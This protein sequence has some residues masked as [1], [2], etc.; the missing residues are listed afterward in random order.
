MVRDQFVSHTCGTGGSAS[1]YQSAE[2]E[3]QARSPPLEHVQ[4]PQTIAELATS[5][6]KSFPPELLGLVFEPFVG[7]VAALNRDLICVTHVC[8]YWRNVALHSP[9]L[10]SHI[11][12]MHPGAVEAFLARSQTLPLHILAD[13]KANRNSAR[14]RTM[15]HEA[16]QVLLGEAACGRILSL[17]V[18]HLPSSNDF[19]WVLRHIARAASQLETLS[20]E[21]QP[22]GVVVIPENTHRAADF[23]G[24]PK[25][26]SLTLRYEIPPL[27]S[28]T[29]NSLSTLDLDMP[30]CGVPRV[31][32]LL[33]CSPSLE[34]LIIRGLFDADTGGVMGTVTLARLR[35]FHL[36]R[37]STRVI[38]ALLSNIALPCKRVNIS[39]YDHLPAHNALIALHFPALRCLKRVQLIWKNGL[40]TLRAYRSSELTSSTAP[41]LQVQPSVS[42]DLVEFLINWPI[43]ASHIETVDINGDSTDRQVVLG[44]EWLWATMLSA[45]PALRTLRVR[46]VTERTLQA[47]LS[48]LKLPGANTTTCPQL[49]TLI[50]AQGS[51]MGESSWDA[52]GVT[53]RLRG[54]LVDA[55]GCLAKIVV[56]Q[57][58]TEPPMC[59]DQ[60]LPLIKMAGVELIFTE[61]Q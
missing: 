54:P 3:G 23:E 13:M 25:L 17:K 2:E 14:S 42:T 31:L 43:D 15:R 22:P 18:N 30:R 33:E 44:Q 51:L 24:V 26:R 5:G 39:L 40:R 41:A 1:D 57:P 48:A 38:T 60:V 16:L 47:I 9:A 45:V 56:E 46:A 6:L 21:R 50:L 10:W 20:I 28:K 61:S 36:Q 32:Y 19:E 27:F 49:E 59:D 11:A 4:E 29:P 12:L 34:H 37:L 8:R 35:T 55:G 7:A 58:V 52:L 53:A